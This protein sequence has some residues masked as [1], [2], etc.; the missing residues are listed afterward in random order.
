MKTILIYC[1]D[2]ENLSTGEWP[3]LYRLATGA[4][5]ERASGAEDL[6][7]PSFGFGLCYALL[8]RVGVP[9]LCRFVFESHQSA[10]GE[11]QAHIVRET[12]DTHPLGSGYVAPC[13]ER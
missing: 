2:R 8:K 3:V 9:D 5:Q 6:G 4:P 12:L 11:P 13:S 1:P 7:H 10:I